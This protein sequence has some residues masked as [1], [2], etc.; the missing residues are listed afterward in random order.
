MQTSFQRI[1]RSVIYYQVYT[2]VTSAY[3]RSTV[4]GKEEEVVAKHN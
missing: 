4:F 3:P 2:R 1:Y